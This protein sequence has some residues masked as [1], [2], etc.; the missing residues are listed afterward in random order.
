M[1]T[2]QQRLSLLINNKNDIKVAIEEQGVEVPTNTPLSGYGDLIRLI[3]DVPETSDIQDILMMCDIVEDLGIRPYV[4]HTYTQD[5]ITELENLVNL[6]VEGGIN[7][8]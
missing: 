3:G 2:T 1:A 7:N 6:I 4:E 8:E 5:D